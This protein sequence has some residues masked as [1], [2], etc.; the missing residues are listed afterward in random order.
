MP[1]Q[2]DHIITHSERD[3]N[4][5]KNVFDKVG[6]ISSAV[7][8]LVFVRPKNQHSLSPL[9]FYHPHLV[10]LDHHHHPDLLL[11]KKTVVGY[12][13]T[14]CWLHKRPWIVQSTCNDVDYH[15]G[16]HPFMTWYTATM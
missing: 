7:A 8:S 9:I 15:F 14:P 10:V 5:S 11:L 4:R 6:K 13:R 12:A 16:K 2:C 1:G 3:D